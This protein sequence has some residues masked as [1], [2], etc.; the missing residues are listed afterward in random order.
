[1]WQFPGDMFYLPPG[2]KV[3]S[4]PTLVSQSLVNSDCCDSCQSTNQRLYSSWQHEVTSLDGVTYNVWRV[5][6]E[7][8]VVG[9]NAGGEA[10]R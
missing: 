9:G 4:T 10:Q 6:K 7:V 1:V 3:R 2:W 8:G 5:K